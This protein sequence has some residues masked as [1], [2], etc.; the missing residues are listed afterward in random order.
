MFK[1]K[2][3]VDT[4]LKTTDKN[5][6]DP[7]N[8][9]KVF[10]KAGT[11]YGVA[12]ILTKVLN[13]HQKIKLGGGAG[14]WVVFSAHWD[15]L[16]TEGRATPSGSTG[17]PTGAEKTAIPKQAIDLI[18]SFE[19][20]VLHPYNDGVGV[21]TIGYGTTIYPNGVKVRMSDSNIT[22]AQAL[23]YAAN[24]LKFFWST[25]G[26]TVPYWNEMN[27]NQRSA[28]LSFGYNL[29][30][31]FYG[32]SGFNTIS[33]VLRN[34]QW[35]KVPQALMLYVNPGSSVEAGLRRRRIAEGRLWSS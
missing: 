9:R 33:T 30:A 23:E 11:S 13:G 26:Q 7:S 12:E 1:I 27:D 5:S 17:F 29:G 10:V 20:L 35:D 2:A 25:I 15:G 28:L 3:K 6:T 32:A 34:R 31:Y 19:G 24:D 16:V 8:N 4:W 14:E 22:H 21:A 18:K